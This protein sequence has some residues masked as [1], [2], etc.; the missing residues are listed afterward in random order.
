[1]RNLP[2]RQVHL[3][4]HTSE[5]IDG[6]G[7]K[8]NKKDFQQA[9][10][11]GHVNSI[12]VFGKCHHGYHYFP[13]KV[14]TMHPG[15]DPQTDLAGEM[16]S[17]CHEIGVHAPLYLTMGW[18][19]LDTKEHPEWI[20]RKKDGSYSAFQYD[21]NA[22]PTDPKPEASWIHLCMGGGY[23]QYLYDMTKEVSPM[24]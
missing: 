11:D 9:L 6:I 20:V 10:K 15:M 16:M 24:D 14:G 5:Y 18:S 1:M 17:A 22:L 3:D 7:S 21:I 12:T 19:V 13:T 8:F 4:F 2:T 23:R